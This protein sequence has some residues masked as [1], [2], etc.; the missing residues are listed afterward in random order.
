MV[1]VKRIAFRTDDR[2]EYF[3]NDPAIKTLTK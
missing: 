2:E 3:M 1:R